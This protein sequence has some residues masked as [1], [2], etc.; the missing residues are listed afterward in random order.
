MISIISYHYLFLAASSA[1]FKTI[2][3]EALYFNLEMPY[4]VTTAKVHA[5]KQQAT[6]YPI[7]FIFHRHR[8]SMPNFNTEML[9]A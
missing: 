5:P 9:L 2:A 6:T 8:G 7:S 1:F 4:L 3:F